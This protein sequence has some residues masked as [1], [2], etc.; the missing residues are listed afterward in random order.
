MNQDVKWS[1][2]GI[3]F[4]VNSDVFDVVWFRRPKMPVL[5]GTAFLHIDDRKHAKMECEMLFHTFWEVISPSAMW[6]NPPSK[7]KSANSKLLQLKKALEVGLKVPETII[8]NNPD[9]IRNFLG[10]YKEV[11][12]KTLYPLSWGKG[13][14]IRSAFTSEIHLHSLP[15][16]QILKLTPGIFQK[17]IQKAYELR[18]TYFGNYPVAVKLCSQKTGRENLDWRSLPVEEMFVENYNLPETINK[19]CKALMRKLG[20]IFGCFDLIVTPDNEYYFLEVNESGQFLWI[21]QINSEIQVLDIFA[22]FLI[23]KKP[24]FERIKGKTPVSISDFQEEAEE[25]V[26][27]TTTRHVM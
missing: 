13:N 12:Y 9:K 14:D 11:V 22:D 16:D 10:L 3:D 26:K 23:N 2:S 27:K 15:S 21:E 6:I 1:S 8:T 20:L 24:T 7:A 25:I 4:A 18:V 5:P 19:K 17:K